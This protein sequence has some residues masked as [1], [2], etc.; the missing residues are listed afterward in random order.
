MNKK[1]LLRITLAMSSILM[2]ILILILSFVVIP[3]SRKDVIK[4]KLDDGEK[5]SVR[6]EHVTLIPGG[7]CEYNV[8]FVRNGSN[9]GYNL[10]VNFVEIEDKNLKEFARVKILS[11][12]E[13]IYDNLLAD[14]YED[15]E[16][17]VPISFVEERSVEFTVSCYL[18]LEIGNEAKNAEAVFELQLT[19]NYE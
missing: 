7:S 6:F 10:H 2:I 11:G 12:D 16:L 4:I 9:R 13:I 19:A 18:P 17:V 8:K 5:E 15:G 3:S 1:T 14:A